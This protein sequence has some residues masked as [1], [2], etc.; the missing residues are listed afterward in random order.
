MKEEI[1]ILVVGG[2][3]AGLLTASYLGAHHRV[4]LIERGRLGETTKYWLTSL[5]RLEKH[6]LSECVLHRPSS[7]VVGTFLGGQL[8]TFGDFVVVNDQ[9]LMSILVERCR[10]V[11]V[12]LAEHSSLVN[13]KW[14]TDHIHV[15]TTSGS[16]T[17]RLLI[18]ASGARSPIAS[19]FRLHK[20]YGFFS[21]YGALLRKVEL[22]SERIVLAHVEQLGDPPPIIE[23][24]PCGNDSAYCSV[25][26]YSKQLTTP[27]SLKAL[28]EQHC[29]NN[30]FFAISGDTEVVS[31]KM[32]A[33]PI[34]RIRRHHLAG[35]VPVGEAGLVQPPLLGSAF[36]EVLEYCQDVCAHVTTILANTSGVPTKPSYRYP[37]LKR[38]QDRLQ[39][40]LMRTL[41]AGNVEVFD[42][43]I[44]TVA[45]LPAETVY[46]LCSNELTWKQIAQTVVKMP[47]YLTRAT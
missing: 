41:L 36:N 21:V 45:K 22:R 47:V 27:Q 42:R 23:V 18:D 5:R 31:P 43:F 30:S 1:E 40:K 37:L 46:D 35:V 44:R 24:F 4:A 26:I 17:T 39:L 19:T 9:L 8:E 11:G 10:N 38:V 34:G 32:G 13:L 3:P 20:L 33:I 29:N 12:V 16:F 7:M 25:F 28:F 2:G 6:A 14:V 15:E